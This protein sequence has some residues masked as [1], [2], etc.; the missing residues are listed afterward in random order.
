MERPWEGGQPPVV[1]LRAKDG[2]V[3]GRKEEKLALYED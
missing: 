1:G 3:L 2:W